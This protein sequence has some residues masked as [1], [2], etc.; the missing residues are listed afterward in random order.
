MCVVIVIVVVLVVALVVALV[1]AVSGSGRATRRLKALAGLFVALVL[2]LVV[3]VVVVVLLCARRRGTYSYAARG[4]RSIGQRD[5]RPISTMMMPMFR[6]LS[7][8]NAAARQRRLGTAQR[9]AQNRRR[10]Q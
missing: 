5:R 7:K 8:H 2:V 10:T 6:R 9:D 1:G 3:V 4:R